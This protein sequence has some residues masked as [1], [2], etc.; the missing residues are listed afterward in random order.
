MGSGGTISPSTPQKV[1]ANAAV[2]F[3]L[4]P[5]NGYVID[6][7]EGTCGGSAGPLSFTTNP[8]TADCTVVAV[9]ALPLRVETKTTLSLAPNPALVNQRVT[10]AV[11]VTAI[12]RS[13]G[14]VTGT[15]V[16]ATTAAKVPPSAV[17]TPT[18]LP[19]VTVSGGGQS[20][21]TVPTD[22]GN[23]SLIGSCVLTFA[24]PGSYAITANYPG[25]AQTQS[26]QNRAEQK[27]ISAPGSYAITANYPGDAQ[28][29]P[30]SDT[31]NLAVNAVVAQQAVP[32]PALSP[33]MLVLLGTILAG[34]SLRH[35]CKCD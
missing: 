12:R 10:A 4:T 23:G 24:A 21:V 27:V 33:W 5:A 28:T 26:G 15:A 16:Q 25:D 32:A 19:T 13:A 34:L 9:Y 3:T 8:V 1:N 6:H 11:T 31:Q 29:L 20:C 7:V 18:A 17:S 14:S 2:T 22:N 30:S 35:A